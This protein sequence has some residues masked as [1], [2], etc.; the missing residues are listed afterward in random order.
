MNTIAKHVHTIHRIIGYHARAIEH[1]N[2]RNELR[3]HA[4][5]KKSVGRL[6][7]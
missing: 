4:N 1:A 5:A 3:K 7:F 2:T 6:R